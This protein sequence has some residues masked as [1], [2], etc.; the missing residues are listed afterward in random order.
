MDF[1]LLLY[2]ASVL[3]FII[4]EEDYTKHTFVQ[5]R[6]FVY[7][8][9]FFQNKNMQLTERVPFVSLTVK[10]LKSYFIEMLKITIIFVIL[11]FL[12]YFTMKISLYIY[13]VGAFVHVIRTQKPR[14]SNVMI[15]FSIFKG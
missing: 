2:F 14:F 15:F 4:H 13:N 6:S 9:V 11:G 3:F 1:R 5:C 7:V 10:I 12:T 8:I